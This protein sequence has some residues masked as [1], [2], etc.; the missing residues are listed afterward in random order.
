MNVANLPVPSGIAGRRAVSAYRRR[1]TPIAGKTVVYKVGFLAALLRPVGVALAIVIVGVAAVFAWNIYSAS[2]I[3]RALHETTVPAAGTTVETTIRRRVADGEVEMILRRSDDSVLRVIAAKDDRDRLVNRMLGDLEVSRQR[4]REQASAA[5]DDAFADAFAGR[6][7]DLD[8]Y[9]DWYFAWGRSWRLLYEA[10][11][12]AGQEM[13]RMGFSRTQVSDAA[14]YAVEDYLLRHYRELV[15]KPAVR[16]PVVSAGILAVFRDANAGFLAAAAALDDEVQRFIGQDA[17]HTERLDADAVKIHIDWDAEMWRAPREGAGD[18]YLA[19][20]RTAVVVAGGAFVLG[21]IVDRLLAH[22]FARATAP[23]LA[24]ARMAVGGAAAGSVGPGLGT[25]IGAL[26]GLALDWGINAFHD[27][28]SR[29]EFI[30]DNA[31]ALDATIAA[32]KGRIMPEVSRA[33]DVWFDDAR[34][35]LVQLSQR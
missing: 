23:V 9:A 8:R 21:P 22:Y 31:A 5:L 12:G 30:A 25:A 4:V 24:S 11:M 1:R 3:R 6:A 15:L 29:D 17:I 7:E 33:I 18:G 13:A 20:A 32:W 2:E 26:G 35:R 14:R 10:L 28:M 19:P 34:A 27:W 16:D